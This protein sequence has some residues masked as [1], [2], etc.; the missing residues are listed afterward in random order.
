MDDSFLEKLTKNAPWNQQ[1]LSMIYSF[2]GAL[3]NPSNSQMTTFIVYIA[4]TASFATA[5]TL[6]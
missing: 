6:P 5:K 3:I 4:D 1:T 2:H